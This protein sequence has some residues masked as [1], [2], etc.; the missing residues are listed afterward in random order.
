[1]RSEGY[2]TWSVCLSVCLSVTQHLTFHVLMHA[3]NNTN[4]LS[5]GWRS[6]SLSD[7]L[8]KCFVAKL[9][10]SCLYGYMISRP[11]FTP[12]KARMRMNLD[13][14]ASGHFVL[15][16]GVL[17]RLLAIGRSMPPTSYARSVKLLFTCKT[18]DVN[19]VIMAECNLREKAICCAKSLALQL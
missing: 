5:G 19:A 10:V 1:M 7:F 6:K 15:R 2:S 11:F 13:H 4:L 9:E 3:T 18:E 17:C 12:Q 14:V 8:W 16:R